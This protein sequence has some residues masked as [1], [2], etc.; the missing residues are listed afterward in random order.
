MFCDSAIKGPFSHIPTEWETSERQ[1]KTQAQ[2]ITD[3]RDFLKFYLIL[4]VD[5]F[6]RKQ[7]PDTH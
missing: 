4:T 6:S 2:A 7:Q 1:E 5:R 3:F